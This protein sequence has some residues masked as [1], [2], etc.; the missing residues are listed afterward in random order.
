M[1]SGQVTCSDEL[2][3]IHGLVREERAATSEGLLSLVH[4]D[5]RPAVV[6]AIEQARCA[7]EP[8]SLD[9]RIVRPGG[10]LRSLHGAGRAVLDDSGSPVTLHGIAQDI[11]DRTHGRDDPLPD[12]EFART[13][14]F[15]GSLSDLA[16]F[17]LADRNG[18]GS[19]LHH[20]QRLT[21]HAGQQAPAR[22]LGSSQP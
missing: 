20:R 18:H 6:E 3:R 12:R 22:S 14:D 21:A 11:T 1:T 17:V 13:A 2:Y 7:H 8:F 9:H 4:P 5:D 15:D 10:E 19:L 16:A